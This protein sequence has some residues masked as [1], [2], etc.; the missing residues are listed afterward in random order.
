M[1]V[2]VIYF[3][4]LTFLFL[5]TGRT[6]LAESEIHPAGYSLLLATNKQEYL[7]NV[8]EV[9]VYGQVYYQ[10]QPVSE[11]LI[12]LE[13]REV[14]I[15]QAVLR[16]VQQVKADEKGKFQWL[17]NK[18]TFKY[19]GDYQVYAAING[20][21]VFAQI[22]FKMNITPP[23]TPKAYLEGKTI[24]EDNSPFAGA[25]VSLFRGE[26]GEQP[27]AQTITNKEGH[28]TFSDILPG[29]Y[30]L[31]VFVPGYKK[32]ERELEIAAGKNN[33]PVPVVLVATNKCDFDGSGEVDDKDLKL[34]LK[35]YRLTADEPGWDIAFDVFP[36]GRI[37]LLDL[38]TAGKSFGIYI[39]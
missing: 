27:V 28:F 1:K 39:D 8:E 7:L 23:P 31:T 6:A 17:I 16:A 26:T 22:N 10:G 18:D 21:T 29:K 35:H 37:D 36:D 15:P 14:S 33:L 11:A 13:L 4:L 12:A 20:T 5:L 38:V 3:I 2:K 25:T 24:K 19:A 9:T 30:R 32:I 34:I